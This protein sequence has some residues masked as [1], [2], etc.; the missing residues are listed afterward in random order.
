MREGRSVQGSG[1]GFRKTTHGP[2]SAHENGRGS[3][4]CA[5]EYPASYH[6][7]LMTTIMPV[8]LHYG[9]EQ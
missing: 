1:D 9:Y 6:T 2:M 8:D 3:P 7:H 5:Q 4:S